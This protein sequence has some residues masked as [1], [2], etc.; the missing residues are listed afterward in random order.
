MFAIMF[1][2]FVCI[3]FMIEGVDIKREKEKRFGKK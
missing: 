1:I 3:I 2:M